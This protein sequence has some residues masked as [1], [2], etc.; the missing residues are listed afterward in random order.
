MKNSNKKLS[1]K[2]KTVFNLN[3]E[4]LNN[5]KGGN[6]ITASWSG[7]GPGYTG[8]CTDGCTGSAVLCTQWNCSEQTC[9]NDCNY[10]IKTIQ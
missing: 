3:D 9:S 8:G 5:V 1:L 10:T 7:C 6:G 4:E 2:K